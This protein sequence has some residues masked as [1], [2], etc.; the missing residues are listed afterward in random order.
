MKKLTKTEKS[1][2]LEMNKNEVAK[3]LLNGHNEFLIRLYEVTKNASI[4]EAIDN[5]LKIME[6]W[7]KQLLKLYQTS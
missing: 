6:M 1:L 2:I 4:K 3:T 7:E 5:H